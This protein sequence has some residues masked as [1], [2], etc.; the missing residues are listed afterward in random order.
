MSVAG[1]YGPGDIVPGGMVSSGYDPGGEGGT[2]PGGY[3][4][5]G[6]MF[7]L[8]RQTNTCENITFPQLRLWPVIRDKKTSCFWNVRQSTDWVQMERMTRVPAHTFVIFFY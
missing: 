6:D 7:P 1:G 5:R 3:G 4:P 8:C 2:V